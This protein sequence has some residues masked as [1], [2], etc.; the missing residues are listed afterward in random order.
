MK[1]VILPTIFLLLALGACMPMPTGTAQNA[2]SPMPPVPTAPPST[3]TPERPL[4]ARVNGQPIYL[5]DY[6][7]QV[8]QYQDALAASGIDI[9]S[10]EG[11]ERLRQMRVQILEWMIEQVLIEQAAAGMNI[12]VSDEEVQAAVAQ[13]VQDA[14]SQEAFQERLERSGMTLQDLQ[15]QLRAELLRARV[16]ERAQATVPERAEQVHARHILVDTRE[17]A[18]A[19]LGQIQAGADFAQLARIYSQDESTRDAGG[20]LGWFPRGILLAPEVE[21]MAFNLQAGQVGPVV[22]SQ[23]GFHIV[24]T[25]ERKQDEPISPEHRQLLQDRAVQRWLESLWNQATIERF[26]E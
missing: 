6:E 1:R 16:L 14:G 12:T 20:D 4:A 2:P 15:V 11:Q 22:Q 5:V 19:L 7:R 24:Q 21:E 8:A 9:A 18:E 23:F 10:P 3:P 26:V 13:L 17:R 25:L